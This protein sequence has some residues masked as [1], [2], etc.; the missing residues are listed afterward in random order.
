MRC[1][2]FL[3]LI[4]LIGT[5]RFNTVWQDFINFITSVA[6]LARGDVQLI[7]FT[8]RSMLK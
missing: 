8:Q 4:A 6:F 2:S 1:A 3:K 7:N 5:L